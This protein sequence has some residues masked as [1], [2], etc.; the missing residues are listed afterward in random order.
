MGKEE[1]NK[2]KLHKAIKN[3]IK[4][5]VLIPQFKEVHPDC[6]KASSP[7]SDSL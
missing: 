2:E 4:K 7:Y 5:N 3:Y 1:D 6:S